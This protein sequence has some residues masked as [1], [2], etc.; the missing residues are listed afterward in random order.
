V[1]LHFTDEVYT[2]AIKG[3]PLHMEKK[4]RAFLVPGTR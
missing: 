3:A 4:G 1:V 2:F